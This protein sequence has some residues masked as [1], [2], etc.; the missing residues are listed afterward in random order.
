LGWLRAEPDQ[1]PAPPSLDERACLFERW[2]DG[3]GR[4]RYGD[5]PTY[6]SVRG[7]RHRIAALVRELVTL[8]QSGQAETARGRLGELEALNQEMLT[9]LMRL[10][11]GAG[12]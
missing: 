1:A 6:G 11:H 8:K 5:S 3:A 9:N 2:L 10:H 7:I 12:D 4:E